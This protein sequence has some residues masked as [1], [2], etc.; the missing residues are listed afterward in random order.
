MYETYFMQNILQKTKSCYPGP[1]I[2]HNSQI[3]DCVTRTYHI[4]F[5]IKDSTNTRRSASYIYLPFEIDRN[6]GEKNK[7]YD[8]RGDCNIPI[9]DF[10]FICSIIPRVPAFGVYIY[11]SA[12]E[13]FQIL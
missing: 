4:E 5:E 12:D 10:P 2:S 11:I 6:Y 9:V 13:I 3:G 7:L 8:K 1:L